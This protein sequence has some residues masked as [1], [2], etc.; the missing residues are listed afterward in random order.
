MRT[1]IFLLCSFLFHT[2]VL[3]VEKDSVAYYLDDIVVEGAI[4]KSSLKIAENG[5]LALEFD[6]MHRLPKILGNADPLR[7]SQFLPGVQ[8]NAEYDAG[9]HIYGC[10]NSHNLVS[11]EGVPVYNPSHMLGLFSV[12]NP[13][14]FASMSLSTNVGAATS[15][16]RI[17][18]TLSMSLRDTIP[19]KTTGSF[20][21]GV[22]SSQG[23]LQLPINAKSLL[24][25][26]FR[27]SY[28]NLLYSSFL[29]SDDSRSRYSFGD[30]NLSYLYKFNKKNSICVDFY[31]G[32]DKLSVDDAK[33]NVT[34]GVK[35]GNTLAAI[36]W[37]YSGNIRINQSLYYTGYKNNLY[38]GSSS[39]GARL[40][41]RINDWGYTADARHKNIT[42]GFSFVNHHIEPQRPELESSSVILGTDAKRY[43]TY[44][45]SLYAQYSGN[46]LRHFA[47]ELAAKGVA[48]VNR[49]T[50]YRHW[51]VNPSA[52]LMYET[53]RVGCFEAGYALQRQY[54]LNTGFTSLGLPVEFW[55]SCDVDKKPY[56]AHSFHFAYSKSL[57]NNKYSVGLN[58]YLKRLF[59]QIE[60]NAT[61]LDFYN[62]EYS[63]NNVIVRG[64]GKN[65]GVNVM[66]KKNGGALTGWVSYTYSR[67]LRRFP[68]YGGG[69]V[70]ANHERIHELNALLT[71]RLNKKWDFGAVFVFASG[72]P[73][74]A[75]K[76]FYLLNGN[77]VSEFGAH[78]ANRT[79]PYSRLDI[80][81]N[82]DIVN[83]NGKNMGIN[84]SLYNVLL[85]DN[86]IYKRLKFYEGKFY[87]SGFSFFVKVLPSIS[88]YYKF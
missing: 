66:V 39:A 62:K 76:H 31:S 44:E 51:S 87:Y 71:Y 52:K 79:K 18:G 75:P 68:I 29:E 13:S 77:I 45:V 86:E 6:I 35:W 73:F 63:L 38:I 55:F 2:S 57:F 7:Y 23:N 21:V 42:V 50:D 48:Y 24:T 8:T 43:N 9:L 84:I 54:L 25:V 60:Y 16:N 83:R 81:A 36:H 34:T 37:K 10:D 14:H 19:H 26:S 47:Y 80:S 5:A 85:S 11:I 30:V 88:F 33:E 56:L 61:P 46:F 15:A 65:Y 1:C 3:G 64:D 20:D 82:Y 12:F 53:G 41:S 69:Y 58:L 27:A 72:N 74:T 28:L 22:I 59:N 4:N 67:A 32:N 78:N 49:T 17:G 40:P 70:P